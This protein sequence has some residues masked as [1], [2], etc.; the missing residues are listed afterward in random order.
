MET[1]NSL[2]LTGKSNLKSWRWQI[3]AFILIS[4]VGATLWPGARQAQRWFESGNDPTPPLV[5]ASG[6]PYVRAL[7][8]TISASESHDPRPYTLLYGGDR[9]QDLS[10]HPDRCVTIVAGPN[11][12][13]CTTAAG[14]YQFITTTWREVA[15]Q[16]HPN[17]DG[18]WFWKSYSF[19]PQYQDAV[20]YAWLSDPQAWGGVDIPALLEQGDLDRVLHLLSP[21]WTSLGYGIED[22]SMTSSLPDIYQDLLA[23]ELAK[24]QALAR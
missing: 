10:H 21:T 22:N 16:Y 18:W 2:Y 14:R 11:R 20:V 9:A 7:M 12:G 5:M 1:L 24:T 15:Q 13:D 23:E 4:L 6:N 3:L 17:P 8:R 19:E